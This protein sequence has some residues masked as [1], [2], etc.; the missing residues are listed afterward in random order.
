MCTK[1]FTR[2]K[3]YLFADLDIPE[4]VHGDWVVRNNSPI[5]VDFKCFQGFKV[6]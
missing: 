1:D 6:L 5:E 2:L 4:T 3:N